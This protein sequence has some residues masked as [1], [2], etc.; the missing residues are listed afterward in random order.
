MPG[1]IPQ[2]FIDD[3]LARTD[4]VDIVDNFVSLR[5]G[6]KNFLG[7]CPFHD[8][9]TPSFTVSQE[10]QFYHCF[11]CGANGTAISF[12]MDYNRMEFLEVIEDLA[13][14]AGLEVPHEGG[15]L[16]SND[17]LTELY[18][19]MELIVRYYRTQLKDHPESKR[20]IDYLKNRGI[21]G[22]L[23]STFE[24]GYAPP[25]WDNLI[26]NFGASQEALNRL[27]KLGMI[28]LRNTG[29]GYYDRFRDRIIYPIRD[30]RSR[31]IGFGGRTLGDDNPKYLNS[32]ETPIFHKGRELYGLPQ[33]K[34]LSKENQKIFVVE[35]YM[36][37]LALAQ[38]DIPNVVATLGVACTADHLNRL[39]RYVDQVIF[40]FDGDEAGK[41]AA[42]RAM[43]ISLPF[44]Q[45]GKQAFF[46]FMPDGIDPDDFVRQNGRDF[47]EDQANM[48]PLSDYLLN[49][50]KTNIDLDNREGRS[51]FVDKATPYI[52]MLPMGALR[53]MLMSDLAEMAKIPVKNIEPLVPE[54]KNTKRIQRFA[55]KSMSSSGSRTPVTIIIEILL[56]RPEL[57]RL[58]ETP[59]ELDEIPDP[60]VSFLREI[61]ELIHSRPD[62]NCA[63]IIENWRGSK[64]E[65]RLKQIAAD[66]D[67][68][69]TA[70]SD[71]E[72]E[73][74]NSLALLKKKRD[75]KSRQI[76]PNK[77]PSELSDEERAQWLQAGNHLNKNP[78]K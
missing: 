71:P 24:L 51:S 62:V 55:T 10:K 18:E 5:K 20:A 47:F 21:T 3:L 41:N 72:I 22:E 16:S 54:V 37:V 26:T 60:G 61:V 27:D 48:V 64:Y 23:A 35:G 53:Q 31:I 11:G 69:I 74:L 67:E 39:Y 34:Q 32:P 63:G 9:K 14:K 50:L 77:R 29:G 13:S 40:C 30:H 57:A 12:L 45:D 7:L 8:E 4:I 75:I 15:Q 66:S 17:G 28:I 58:I 19:L 42:W 65:N 38:F 76:L 49:T 6:G 59:S 56:A 68:R 44:L 1:R 36:D 43:E 70:L 25:G 33:A 2:T 46:I 78:K 52:S 73:L